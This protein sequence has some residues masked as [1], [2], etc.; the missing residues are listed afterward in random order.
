[1]S[2]SQKCFGSLGPM[3]NPFFHARSR[4]LWENDSKNYFA[5]A[6]LKKCWRIALTPKTTV[7]HFVGSTYVAHENN[8]DFFDFRYK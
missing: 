7:K 8:Q 3:Y 5:G 1:M 4:F 2:P 6:F